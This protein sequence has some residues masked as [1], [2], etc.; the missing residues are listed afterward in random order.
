MSVKAQPAWALMSVA[1]ARRHPGVT[2][3]AVAILAGRAGITVSEYLKQLDGV[4]VVLYGPSSDEFFPNV[5]IVSDTSTRQLAAPSTLRER[6]Q[7]IGIDQVTVGT[8]NSLLGRI[9]WAAIP[10]TSSGE[11]AAFYVITVLAPNALL[12]I[13]S[14]NSTVSRARAAANRVL[15]NIVAR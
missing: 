11:R 4:D 10:A 6:L 15:G 2:P 7:G 1:N 12:T 5:N 3:P 8:R 14:S 13:T 9:T